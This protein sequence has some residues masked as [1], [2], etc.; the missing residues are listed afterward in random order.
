MC[1]RCCAAFE[2]ETDR[3]DHMRSQEQ[4]SVRD[5]PP[6]RNGFNASQRD[7]LKS[8]PKGYKLMSE[9]QKWR[10]VYKILFP[11]VDD[12]DIPSPCMC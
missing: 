2:T 4:C 3:D 9:P 10:Y 6:R 11:E 1:V 8:R 5:P 12:A 7:Q